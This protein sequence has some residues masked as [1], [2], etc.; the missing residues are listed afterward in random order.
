[1]IL[2]LDEIK[3]EGWQGATSFWKDRFF[4]TKHG[5]HIQIRDV[6]Y[7]KTLFD[8][9]CYDLQTFRL[10]CNLIGIE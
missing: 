7:E 8:G 2:T 6:G 9:K 10:I 3:E 1:M 4:L 5:D